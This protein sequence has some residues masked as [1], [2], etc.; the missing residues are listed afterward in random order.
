M[1]KQLLMVFGV[2]VL[3]ITL[4]CAK[5]QD[6]NVL[7]K[8]GTAIVKLGQDTIT[9]EQL[10]DELVKL[11]PNIKTMFTGKDGLKR[12]V[13]EIKKREVLYL[14]AKKLGLDK[15]PEFA[16]KLADFKKINL[17]N[18]L[19]QKNVQTDNLK[20]TPE[21]AKDYFD[22]NQKEF[23][24]PEQVRAVHILVKT[25]KEAKD[26]YDKLKKGADFASTAKSLSQDTATADKGGDLGFFA[27]GQMEPNFD[28]AVF[29]LKKGE[30]SNPVKTS[31]GYHII[32]AV[33]TKEAK[34][35]EFESV[36]SMIMQ[37][38]T[39]D[40]QKKAFDNYY[41]QVE[42][43]YAVQIDNKALDEFI[44]KQAAQ[45]AAAPAPGVPGQGAPAPGGAPDAAKPAEP[46]K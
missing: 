31:F 35:V 29:K 17:I 13:D 23:M 3:L 41:S 24:M 15:D 46:H 9:S 32:K 26:V 27:R 20:V 37:Y 30:L 43:N 6:D 16:K 36:K 11:P 8:G 28:D 45:P 40:K 22:K 5:T 1:K 44:A 14:E 12:L 42:K 7:K 38:L 19:I 4:A 2:G 18:T 34:T 10:Q 39:G 21:E 25:E 33:D